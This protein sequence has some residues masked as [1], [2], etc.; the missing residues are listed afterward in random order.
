MWKLR[1]HDNSFFSMLH[2][3]AILIPRG[4]AVLQQLVTNQLSI[5]EAMS[6]LNNLQD[7]GNRLTAEVVDKVSKSYVPPMDRED[8][9]SLAKQLNDL[10]RVIHATVERLQLYHLQEPN[11]NVVNLINLLTET[12]GKIPDITINLSDIRNKAEL[13]TQWCNVI[14]DQENEADY[15]YRHALAELFDTCKGTA[16]IIKWR[17]ICQH[18]EK[19][20]DNCERLADSIKGAVM[21]YV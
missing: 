18:L 11:Q 20:F 14:G 4:G 2:D 19:A 8:I 10:L 3:I 13:I 5:E 15:Y 6:S 17:D 16:E 12:V 9:Y 7:E 1:P 21:K